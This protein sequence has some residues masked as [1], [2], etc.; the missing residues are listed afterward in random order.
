MNEEKIIEEIKKAFPRAEA[1]A[2]RARRVEVKLSPDELYDFAVRMQKDWGFEHLSA[3]SCVDWLD[4][5]QFELVYD[6]WS[7]SH[8][9]LVMAK[10]RIERSE[11]PHFKSIT[12][13]WQPAKFFE[14]DIHEMF[15]IVFDGNEDLSKFILTDWNGPPPMRKDFQ[16]REFALDFFT[17]KDTY[18]TDWMEELKAMGEKK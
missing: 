3:I 18:Q 7:Y 9:I 17:F 12:A 11:E 8:K 1:L 10:I 14:R 6:F 15:G 16:T 2:K 13:L 4:Q 5:G